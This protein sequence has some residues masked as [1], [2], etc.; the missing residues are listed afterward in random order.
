MD[1]PYPK[2][3]TEAILYFKDGSDR[4]GRTQAVLRDSF[5]WGR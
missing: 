2:T 3:L 1:T 5:T 4:P